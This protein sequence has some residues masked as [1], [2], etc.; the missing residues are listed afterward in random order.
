MAY[1]P[2]S[3]PGRAR[4][5]PTEWLRMNG[6]KMAIGTTADVIAAAEGCL[7]VI[8][9]EREMA[10]QIRENPRG[11]LARMLPL[12]AQQNIVKGQLIAADW[13]REGRQTLAM[14]PAVV[15]ECRVATSDR[16]PGEVLRVLPYINP[17]VIYADPPI[18][19]SWVKQTGAQG[20]YL[21]QPEREESMKLLGFFTFSHSPI[22][23]EWTDEIEELRG[24]IR[25]TND[26][27]SNYLGILAIFE[28]LDV[29][30]N[31]IDNEMNSLSIP[32]LQTMTLRELVNDLADR[33]RWADQPEPTAAQGTEAT[34]RRWMREVMSV[35][36]GTLFYLCSTTLE[37]ERVPARAQRRLI[38]NSRE[39]RP[40]SLYR[41]GWTTG[42][43]L[44]R[45]RAQQSEGDVDWQRQDHSETRAGVR[46]LDTPR[47]V[48]GGGHQHGASCPAATY[49][50]G[51]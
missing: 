4:E 43:A 23:H 44:T 3:S 33:F 14:H 50:C 34:R 30:G 7:R 12:Q 49:G 21:H 45:L 2:G 42:A 25:L 37:A 22:Y 32:L 1:T 51:A 18:F 29:H 36:V 5:L 39:R 6:E 47:E 24:I 13:R 17:F 48:R 20:T 27:E 16:V 9:R 11:R 28:I 15:D 10:E 46:V 31:R 26:G 41:V 38:A 40:L 35:V 19:K 8:E